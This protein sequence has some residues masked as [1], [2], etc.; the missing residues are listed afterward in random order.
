MRLSRIHLKCLIF[1]A[2]LIVPFGRA[3][4]DL[5]VTDNT[6]HSVLRYSNA[7]VALGTFIP[8]GSGGQLFCTPV[9]GLDGNLYLADQ[10]GGILRYNGSTG[11][12]IDKFVPAGSGG[13]IDACG[14]TLGPDANLYVSDFLA[15]VVR[16]YNG[17]TGA[18]MGVFTTG[19][20]LA[21]PVTP[22]FGPDG[23]LYVADEVNI[24]K[25]NGT[26]GA[27]ISVF[28]AA[29]SGGLSGP[30]IVAF[31]PDGN[32]WIDSA[33]SGI[34]RYDPHTG[35]FLNQFVPDF[36]IRSDGGLAFGPDGNVYVAYFNAGNPIDFVNEYNG[37]TGALIGTVVPAGAAGVIGGIAFTPT[38]T[39]ATAVVPSHGGNAGTVTV[40]VIGGNFQPGAQLKLTGNG[41]DIVGSRAPTASTSVIA[42]AF[43]L[44]GAAVGIWNVVVV[45]PNNTT[46]VLPGAFT[47]DQGGGSQIWTQ[48]VGKNLI[49]FGREQGFFI[50]YG[51]RG[52]IDALGVQLVLTFPTT[53]ASSLG[54][55]NEVGLVSTG[56]FGSDTVVIVDLGKVS[57]SSTSSLPVFL[58]TG[59]S[60][61]PFN[62]QATIRGH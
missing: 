4:A 14:L 20:S 21:A 22:V 16:R 61:A 62:I 37:Q 33:H 7:G 46:V 17:T 18:S 8:P 48:I 11:A 50:T 52:N 31:G 35:A 49:R 41:P 45:N 29:G 15:N 2:A 1:S 23:N 40:Q 53:L 13:L 57:A 43:D 3:K 6:N 10:Q 55:G 30:T 39:Q 42:T 19:Y 25:F 60:Q 56:S 5:L 26:T 58:T 47:V 51:N 32:L 36:G 44:R 38:K 27:F 34:T 28:V 9:F 24:V 59:T 12:F 54:F